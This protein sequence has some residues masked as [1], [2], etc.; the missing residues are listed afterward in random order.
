MGLL[1]SLGRLHRSG[2]SPTRA[3]P[4]R[5]F[6]SFWALS[7]KTTNDNKREY[8]EEDK[9]ELLD[10]QAATMYRGAAAKLNYLGL[11]RPDLQFAA[12][13]VQTRQKLNAGHAL[14]LAVARGRP[15]ARRAPS[16][17]AAGRAHM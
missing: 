16:A 5:V 15:I 4:S 3:S 6:P 13:E 7:R 2:P 1:A 8:D 9:S 12:K 11:D 14:Q 17:T 10:G